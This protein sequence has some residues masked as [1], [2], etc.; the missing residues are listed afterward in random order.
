MLI[1]KFESLSNQDVTIKEAVKQFK[2]AKATVAQVDVNKAIK[3]TSGIPYREIFFTFTDSQVI[4][5]RIKES[6]DIYQVLLNRK[7]IP[8]KS[9][10]D[11]AKAIK[12]MAGLMARGRVAFQKR[13]ARKK[14][15]LPSSVK[16]SAPKMEVLLS[17]RLEKLKR[18]IEEAKRTLDELNAA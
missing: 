16:T 10:D 9:Q 13:Q 5:L 6:G 3:K 2:K 8:I 14:V 12:E 17:D 7:L 15:A 18:E 4:T 1:F 11:H